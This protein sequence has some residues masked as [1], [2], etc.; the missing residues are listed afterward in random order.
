MIEIDEDK[1]NATQIVINVKTL[2]ILLGVILTGLTTLFG[3]LTAKISD[4]DDKIDSIEHVK[5]VPLDNGF[6]D[7]D[8]KVY[9]LIMRTNSRHDENTPEVPVPTTTAPSN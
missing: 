7:L 9:Y 8:K 1:I 2:L 4:V 6:H 5:I 3:I